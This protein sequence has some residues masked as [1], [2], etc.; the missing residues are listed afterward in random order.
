MVDKGVE[1]VGP[2]WAPKIHIILSE[3]LFSK[4]KKISGDAN[5]AILHQK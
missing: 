1:G 2:F 4:E 5:I 3:F